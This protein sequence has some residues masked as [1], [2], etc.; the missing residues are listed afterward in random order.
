MTAKLSE[1]IVSWSVGESGVVQF[2]Y[3]I[4]GKQFLFNVTPET[5]Q[6]VLREIGRLAANERLPLDW[7]DA[8]YLTSMVREVMEMLHPTPVESDDASIYVG[9]DLYVIGWSIMMMCCSA[10]F[11]VALFVFFVWGR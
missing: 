9:N 11:C 1:R 7:N 10:T 6:D 5:Q 8:A 3:S 4:D 2:R